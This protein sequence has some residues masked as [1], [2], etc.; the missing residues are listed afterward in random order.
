MESGPVGFVV[1]KSLTT[2]VSKMRLAELAS[3]G[4]TRQVRRGGE[5]TFRREGEDDHSGIDHRGEKIEQIETAQK[6]KVKK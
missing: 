5:R 2:S 6:K 1:G 3:G 4:G